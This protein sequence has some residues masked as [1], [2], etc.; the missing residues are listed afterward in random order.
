VA[1][2]SD[3]VL[4]GYFPELAMTPRFMLLFHVMSMLMYVFLLMQLAKHRTA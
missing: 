1:A 2:L 3:I 4:H